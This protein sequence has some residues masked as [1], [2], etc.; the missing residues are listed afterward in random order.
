MTHLPSTSDPLLR[1]RIIR[2]TT[3]SMTRLCFNIESGLL[4]AA[5]PSLLLDF[6]NQAL[7]EDSDIN[8]D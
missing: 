3:C 5:I 1:V 8:V 7:D 4:H 2:E 6:A